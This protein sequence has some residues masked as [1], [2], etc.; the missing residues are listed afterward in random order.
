MFGSLYF[1]LINYQLRCQVSNAGT[2]VF[3]FLFFFVRVRVCVRVHV[4]RHDHFSCFLIP[5]EWTLNTYCLINNHRIKVCFYLCT[6]T[7]NQNRFY[8]YNVIIFSIFTSRW[9][10]FFNLHYCLFKINE[11]RLSIVDFLFFF[12]VVLK[13][14][15]TVTPEPRY[16]PNRDICVPCHPYW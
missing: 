1:I 11:K 12:P 9:E 8:I 16:V 4:L 13:S 14:Y 6:L 15:R 7:M 10:F 5:A 2:D 3:F